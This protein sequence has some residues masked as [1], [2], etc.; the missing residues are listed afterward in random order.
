MSKDGL[1]RVVGH[2]EK[3]Q[4]LHRDNGRH[5]KAWAHPNTGVMLK[6][7]ALK[8]GSPAFSSTYF[9]WVPA[10]AQHLSLTT[11]RSQELSSCSDNSW[12]SSEAPPP[13]A[14][15]EESTEDGT[16]PL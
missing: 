2:L 7:G 9:S 16:W 12:A 13:P 6:L 5:P 15:A 10:V 4:L 8:R 1:W 11:L 3:K 14:V